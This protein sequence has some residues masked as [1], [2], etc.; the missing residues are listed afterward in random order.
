MLVADHI[1]DLPSAFPLRDFVGMSLDRHQRKKINMHSAYLV[2]S[3]SLALCKVSMRVS[4]L[5][6]RVKFLIAAD[7]MPSKVSTAKRCERASMMT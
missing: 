6:H 1:A 7:A 3:D 2:S 5:G 4:G